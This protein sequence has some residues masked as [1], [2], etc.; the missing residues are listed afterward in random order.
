MRL[1]ALLAS[2]ASVCACNVQPEGELAAYGDSVTL[3]YG[4]LPGGW[5]RRIEQTSGYTVTNLA[6]PGEYA[7]AAAGRIDVALRTAPKAKVVFLMHGGNDWIKAFRSSQ[8]NRACE[9]EAVDNKYE[10]VADALRKIRRAIDRR[11]DK[12]VFLTYWAGTNAKCPKY[13]AETFKVYQRHRVYLNGKIMAV[14]SEHG[15]HVIRTDT[16]PGFADDPHDYYDCLHPS[17]QGYKKIAARIFDD[18]AAW[19]PPEPGPQDML[20]FRF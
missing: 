4:D 1:A 11:G 15:D 18:F 13:D 6:I 8:C 10:A 16:M 3:G 7:A 20:R 2:L 17:A 14:A 9:P 12:T 19:E 5:V